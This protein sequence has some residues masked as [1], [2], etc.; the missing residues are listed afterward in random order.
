LLNNCVRLL[1]MSENNFGSLCMIN[2]CIHVMCGSV[3]DVKD[4]LVSYKELDTCV[5]YL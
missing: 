5:I 4:M 1:C 3:V 2:C